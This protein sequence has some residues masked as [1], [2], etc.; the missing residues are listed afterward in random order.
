MVY[1]MTMSL[2][3][4]VCICTETLGERKSL[5]RLTTCRKT[6]KRYISTTLYEIA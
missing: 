6:S 2:P 4:T 1:C 3:R 5:S